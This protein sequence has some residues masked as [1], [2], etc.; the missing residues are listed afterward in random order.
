MNGQRENFRVLHNEPVI[1]GS[2]VT[3]V[4]TLIHVTGKV[5]QLLTWGN[6]PVAVVRVTRLTR[7]GSIDKRHTLPLANLVRWLPNAGADAD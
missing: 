4:G 1:V 2:W 7:Y 5:E 3:T 6:M